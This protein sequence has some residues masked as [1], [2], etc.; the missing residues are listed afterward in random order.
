MHPILGCG[1]I[2]HTAGEPEV[3]KCSVPTPIASGSA[4]TTY[5][6]L[7]HRRSAS[8][9]LETAFKHIKISHELQPDVYQ[10]CKK[11]KCQCPAF[12]PETLYSSASSMPTNPSTD[13]ADIPEL[14]GNIPLQVLY[15]PIQSPSD[16]EADWEVAEICSAP[17]YY[18]VKS[19]HTRRRQYYTYDFLDFIEEEYRGKRRHYTSSHVQGHPVEH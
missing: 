3:N 7:L 10:E 11:D 16:E 19:C 14:V 15:P 1:R 18:R 8:L 2:S 5:R 6:R 12:T 17:V 13:D 4:V 9:D